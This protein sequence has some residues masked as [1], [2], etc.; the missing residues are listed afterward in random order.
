MQGHMMLFRDAM[1]R[2]NRHPAS[3]AFR[4]FRRIRDGVTPKPSA[5]L[6]SATAGTIRALPAK[7]KTGPEG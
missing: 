4:P 2:S 7:S 3:T 1:C 6:G 5:F